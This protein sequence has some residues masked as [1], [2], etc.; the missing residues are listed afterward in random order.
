MDPWP[1]RIRLV[2]QVERRKGREF[3]AAWTR[4]V[5]RWPAPE[6]WRGPGYSPYSFAKWVFGEAYNQIPLKGSIARTDAHSVKPS[7]SSIGTATTCRWGVGCTN[8]P[9]KGR[10]FCPKHTAALAAVQL[11]PYEGAREYEYFAS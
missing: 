2:L 1:S 4:A 10:R 11:S 7:T 9:V 3:P 8:A 6:S 5:K